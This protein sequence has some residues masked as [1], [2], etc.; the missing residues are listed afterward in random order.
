M[1][2]FGF[3]IVDRWDAQIARIVDQAL[4]HGAPIEVGLYFGDARALG[5]LGAQLPQST[6]PIAAHLNHRQLSLLGIRH[7]ESRLRAQL[8]VAAELGATL[9]VTHLGSYPMTARRSLR[10]RLW[11]E[12][13]ADLC[14]A[15]TLASEYGLRLH[16]ENTFHDLGFYQA[17]L[18]GLETA[19]GSPPHFCFDIGHA[20]VWSSESL[21]E[22]LTF[23]E[24]Q[25]Q[26]GAQ[27]HFHLHA[28]QGLADQ[29]R[30]FA[31]PDDD[32]EEID[33]D[34]MHGMDWREVLRLM[35]R[36]FPSAVKIFEVPPE[37]TI[38]HYER[39]MAALAC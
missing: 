31:L 3:K 24:A 27:L 21:L 13:G 10:Q 30:S 35:D 36:R 11:Q 22:W 38:A 7:R 29:H 26:R 33:D 5:L 28:N 2:A 39:V 16:I 19:R 23:L 18:D 34:F 8:G 37:E 1:P 12:L 25:T 9:A 32:A 20:K 4:T 6:A 14:F 15:E 17:L